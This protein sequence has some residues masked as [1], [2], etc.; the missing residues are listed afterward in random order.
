MNP[1]SLRSLSPILLALSL[2]A[3]ASEDDDTPSQDTPA[4]PIAAC[5]REVIEPDQA[6]MGPPQGAIVNPDTKQINPPAG[7]I[8]ATTYLAIKPNE[9]AGQRFGQVVGPVFQDLAARQGLLGITASNSTACNTAR[10]LTV[11]ESEAAMM[12]F[13][14]GEAHAAA[15]QATSDISRGSSVTMTWPHAGGELTWQSAAARLKD[16]DGPI[17]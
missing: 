6:F 10:T 11:W 5:K 2:T 17:Y 15:M 13:V 4:D 16:H 12:A 7:A 8:V 9:Q 14:T 1:I 3:C